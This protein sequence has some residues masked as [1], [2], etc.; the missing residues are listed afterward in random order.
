MEIFKLT[1]LVVTP[2]GVTLGT[3]TLID[4]VFITL[5]VLDNHVLLKRKRVKKCRQ[6]GRIM[7]SRMLLKRRAK[8]VALKTI[9]II[10]L[11]RANKVSALMFCINIKILT[12]SP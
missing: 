2:T 6:P 8:F 1:Q 4:R 3:S 11:G 9:I 5:Y 12:L 10:K 7:K